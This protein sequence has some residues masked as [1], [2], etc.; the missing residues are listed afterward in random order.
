MKPIDFEKLIISEDENYIFINKPSHISTLDE[1]TGEGESILRL[2]KKYHFD[3]QTCHRLDKETSGILAIAK[4]PD[5]YR[6]MSLKFQNR[7]I[8]KRYHAVVDGIHQLKDRMV[9]LPITPLQKGIVK[10]DRAEGKEAQTIFNTAEIFRK[11]TLLECQPIT[12]RMHQIR[13]HLACLQAS[14]VSDIQYGGKMLYL[15]EIKRN[16]K[17]KKNT[18]EQPL[19]SRIAL[20]ARSLTFENDKNE[21]V[22]IQAEYPK[23]MAAL[24]KQLRQND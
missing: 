24:L 15:S 9:D 18:D 19:I 7:E 8:S 17:L 5:A 14:I 4:N 1:R 2:A 11:H 16:F 10:I 13:I 6:F 3:A 20:H 12:G 21:K 23:D 22:Q